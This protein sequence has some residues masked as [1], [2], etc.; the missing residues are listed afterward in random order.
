MQSTSRSTPHRARIAELQG[1][2]GGWAAAAFSGFDLSGIA[3]VVP[4]SQGGS[5]GGVE[6]GELQGTMVN[7]HTVQLLLST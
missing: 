5:G 6:W 3:D 4:K 2:G 1:I 7:D